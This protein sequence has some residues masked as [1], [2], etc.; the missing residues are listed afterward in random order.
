MK[1]YRK[2]LRLPEKSDNLYKSKEPEPEE[3]LGQWRERI[4]SD[5]LKIRGS[6]IIEDPY[7]T[8]FFNYCVYCNQFSPDGC[9]NVTGMLYAEDVLYCSKLRLN[10]KLLQKK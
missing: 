1:W 8:Y 4:E 2:L 3:T 5:I 9:F 6:K 10:N 7:I